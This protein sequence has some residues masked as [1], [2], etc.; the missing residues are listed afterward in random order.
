MERQGQ[1]RVLFKRASLKRGTWLACLALAFAIVPAVLPSAWG[2]VQSAQAADTTSTS[3]ALNAAQLES[4]ETV[5]GTGN[6]VFNQT[7]ATDDG[8]LAV[9]YT[10]STDGDMTGRTTVMKNGVVAFLGADASTVQKVYSYGG[11]KATT[12]TSVAQTSDGDYVVAGYT[13][14]NQITDTAGDEASY[15][16]S[17]DAVLMKVTPDGTVVWVKYFGGSSADYFYKVI[18]SGDDIIAVGSTGSTNGDIITR[19]GYI[20]AV[21]VAYDA[22]GT[23]LW[24]TQ[25]GGTSDVNCGAQLNSLTVDADGNVYVVGQATVD[26]TVNG[27][28]TSGMGD[29][30]TV[31]D[32]GH[33]LATC[34][35]PVTLSF[36]GTIETTVYNGFVAKLDPSTGVL[37]W[38]QANRLIGDSAIACSTDG[39]LVVTGAARDDEAHQVGV[40]NV[41]ATSGVLQDT[42]QLAGSTN[43]IGLYGGNNSYNTQNFDGL[44]V[45]DIVQLADGTFVGVG[46]S[47]SDASPDAGTTDSN[48]AYAFEYDFSGLNHTVGTDIYSVKTDA[49]L[50]KFDSS[51]D[52]YWLSNLGGSASDYATSILTTSSG[53]YA[54]AGY[55]YSSDG[56]FSSL[57]HGTTTFADAYVATFSKDI[58]TD[59]D[60]V[61]NSRDAYPSDSTQSV[62]AS[63]YDLTAT[64]KLT[65]T[66]TGVTSSSLYSYLLPTETRTEC[67]YAATDNVLFSL[68]GATVT[69]P[70]A[71]L[72][73]AI[74]TDTTSALTFTYAAATSD[75]T[76]AATALVDTNKDSVATTFDL[77]AS[78]GSTSLSSLAGDVRVS[79]TLDSTAVSKVTDA[80]TAKLYS[81][82]DGA[83]VEVTGATVDTNADTLTFDTASPSGTYVLVQ[84][85]GAVIDAQ[86]LNGVYN[87]DSGLG[88]SKV[89]DIAGNSDADGARAQLY[90]ANG[91]TAQ[92]FEVTYTKTVDGTAYYTVTSVRSGKALDVEGG[93]T[94]DGTRVQQYTANGTDAQ[95]WALESTGTDG[96]YALVSKT[97]GKALDITGG[98]SEDGTAAQIYTAN[99]STAQT[100]TLSAVETSDVTLSTSATYTIS[101][102]LRGDGSR[103]LDISG[104]STAAGV[105][106]DVWSSNGTA[107]QHFTLT[108]D[109]LGYYT[110][111]N[112]GSGKV[113]DVKGNGIA[114]GT[115]VWQYDSNGTNAQKWALRSNSDGT[116][117]LV[118]KTSGK[119]LDLTG[120]SSYDGTAAQI[121]TANGSAAQAFDFT[122]TTATIADVPIVAAADSSGDSIGYTLSS[123]LGTDAAGKQLV[124]DIAGGSTEDG[125]RAQVWAANGTIAQRYVLTYLGNDCYTI[126]CGVS[127]KV[128]TATGTDDGA[129]VVQDAPDGSTL[130]QW[131]VRDSGTAN[132]DGDEYYTLISKAS[133]KALDL[134]GGAATDGTAAQVYTANGSAAQFFSFT[135]VK[136]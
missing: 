66:S 117:T 40:V 81:V 70:F 58:D 32:G 125:A 48:N 34:L 111:T 65:A 31:A 27:A 128:L 10:S 69:C 97:S 74:G 134:T 130:Q 46:Y 54:V 18:V 20:D 16:G 25:I 82:E 28:T 84:V 19:E 15:H 5:G 45:K 95:L 93:A 96:S 33:A 86:S 13:M 9:G 6:D 115:E 17:Y 90:T 76:S 30:A 120:G 60:G 23:E 67:S 110:V 22:D 123:A 50:I 63:G 52:V 119:V 113:L 109:A 41:L 85:D 80:S 37:Q 135:A 112:V 57:H 49:Y 79:V 122:S 36:D 105:G 71:Y 75:E 100:F 8:Y 127:G 72:D 129:T 59:G 78:L 11:S 14:G 133:G 131:V 24:Q 62:L 116:V 3:N 91:T 12:F 101:S 55:E 106:L 136:A 47:L 7:I 118:S 43:G 114:N 98:S 102:S 103:V 29:F 99:G 121:Y 21:A 68:D 51:G 77:G 26:T 56:D 126:E 94:A 89:L 73:A 92:E 38:V 87:L 61:P 53:G 104:G 124:L 108:K 35:Q 132:A 39:S 107:A 4:V 42:T 1:K 83:L 64:A 44:F 2:T 88:T